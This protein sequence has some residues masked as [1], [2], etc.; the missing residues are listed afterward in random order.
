MKRFLLVLVILVSS[1]S[2]SRI[3]QAEINQWSSSEGPQGADINFLLFS[4]SQP[5]FVATKGK[6]VY[7]YDGSKWI[8][9][10]KN[11]GLNNLYVTSLYFDASSNTLYAGTKGGGVFKSTDNQAWQALA[12]N[13]GL[14]NLFISSLAFNIN[15]KILYAGTENGGVYQKKPNSI[16][17]L[18]ANNNEGLSNSNILSLASDSS[19]NILYA[20]TKGGGVFRK[21]NGD[22]AWSLVSKNDGLT[23]LNIYSLVLDNSTNPKS[24][25]AATDEGA[26]KSTGGAKWKKVANNIGLNLV[27]KKI[28]LLWY[29]QNSKTLY[30][31]TQRGIF[32]SKNNKDWEAVGKTE[33]MN[34][35]IQGLSWDNTNQ[36]LYAAGQG[37]VFKK[38][39]TA[40]Q[41]LNSEGLN[42]LSIQALFLDDVAHILYAG[43]KQSG[44]F[45]K[46]DVSS[47]AST[48][49]SK[50]LFVEALIKDIK[51]NTLYAGTPEGIYKSTN[52]G[53][54]TEAGLNNPPQRVVSFAW[55]DATQTLYAGTLQ[56]VFQSV[57]GGPWTA[58]NNGLQNPFIRALLWDSNSKT[59]Y[60]ALDANVYMTKGQNWS[61]VTNADSPSSLTYD[62]NT[63]TLYIGTGG[64]G[65]AKKNKDSWGY[66]ANNEG[67]SNKAI[68][69][70]AF[71]NSSRSLVAGTANGV[72]LSKQEGQWSIVNSQGLSPNTKVLSLAIASSN[73]FKIY[74]G[75]ELGSVFE[76]TSP[77]SS[78]TN[79]INFGDQLLSSPSAPQIV[80]LHNN[81]KTDLKINKISASNSAFALQ[82]NCNGNIPSLKSC[83]ISLA[84]MPDKLGAFSETLLIEDGSFDS[85]H[86]IQL[87]GNG[88]SPGVEI[89]PNNIQF[90]NLGIGMVSEGGIISVKNTGTA[91]LEIGNISLEGANK[92]EFVLFPCANK[93]NIPPQQA[94]VMQVTFNP[95]SIGEKSAQVTMNDNSPSK[96]HTVPLG[97]TGVGAILATSAAILS[98]PDTVAGQS[99][100]SQTLSLVNSGNA[101]LSVGPIT[102]E[103]EQNANFSSDVSAC[104]N[105]ALK[106]NSECKMNF[107]FK[108]SAEG[109]WK[110]NLKIES[111]TPG[112]AQFVLLGGKGI[113]LIEL[114]NPDP[115]G[116]GDKPSITPED[117]GSGQAE[118]NPTSGNTD[119]GGGGG[120]ACK[121]QQGALRSNAYGMLGLSFLGLFILALKRRKAKS[122]LSFS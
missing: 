27:T 44:V 69:S 77:M 39:P 25:F 79:N 88:V 75:T 122:L 89:T 2:P 7:S 99:S 100:A 64:N 108:P 103:G 83:D 38:N 62:S 109:E 58:N 84:F 24:L 72:F 118:P 95:K 54:W 22:V 78:S 107:T 23:N 91:V 90:Q 16:W 53:V 63:Q 50:G 105:L 19:S 15:T 114:Q 81:G 59:L 30:A 35:Y 40:W 45:K 36:T 42:N 14:Q 56:G 3:A 106:P 20:G 21:G 55:D 31:G 17:E 80:T 112:G 74:A 65:V 1:F 47:W 111:N 29:E 113:K 101:N 104:A 51:T 26:F 98:F 110:A 13:N 68:H 119:G 61:L 120:G 10:A 18:V 102:L 121:L 97:G 8:A 86:A 60:A 92:D 49:N 12:Q 6:G 117:K 76:I 70:L 11:E 28:T 33:E 96:I 52:D 94:C 34:F 41:M 71:E 116:V 4:P 93:K 66:V 48:E 32:K 82:E 115:T 87:S 43:T 9:V 46:I 73:P 37:R 5:L 67:L 57:G 85:P